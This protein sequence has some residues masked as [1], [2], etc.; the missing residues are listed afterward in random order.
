MQSIDIDTIVSALRCLRTPRAQSEYDLHALVAEALDAA[1]ISFCHEVRIAPRRR[2]DF[3][4]GEVGI[5]V[6]RGKPQRTQLL[7]QLHAYAESESVQALVLVTE[8]APILPNRLCD[9][10]LVAISLQS[11]WGI[12]L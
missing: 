7:A 8:R 10:P 2:I 5:E 1:G 3:M 11:L 6:K 12:A 9:K 4:A